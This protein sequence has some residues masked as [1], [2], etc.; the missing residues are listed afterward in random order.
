MT[1][2]YTYYAHTPKGITR[3]MVVLPTGSGKTVIFSELIKRKKLKTLVIAHR[4]EL[5]EQ[6]EQKLKMVAPD[7]EVGIF[8]GERKE[9]GKQVTIAS[10]QSAASPRHRE[11]FLKEDFELLIIDEAHHASARTY[12]ELVDY[13]G[14]K[15]FDKVRNNKASESGIVLGFTA[16]AKRGDRKALKS[17][18]DKIVYEMQLEELVEKD[19]LTRPKGLHV[20]VDIDLE[21]V[22]TVM[23][24]YKKLSLRKVMTS[25][26]AR[27]IVAKTIKKFA[28]DRSG[29]VFSCDINH[30]EM[31]HQDI[32]QAGFKSAVVHSCV[33]LDR[34]KKVLKDFSAGKLQFL[35]NPM[36]LTEGFDCPIA[37]CMIN[38]A[39]T[40]NRPLYI[41]KAGRVLRLH[42]EKEDAL[43][44]DFGYAGEESPL[45]TAQTL[46]SYVE[47]KKVDDKLELLSAEEKEAYEKKLLEELEEER[48]REEE[49]Q[50]KLKLE[51][52]VEQEYD[53]LTV[54]NHDDEDPIPVVKTGDV[55]EE[56]EQT[57]QKG[58]KQ[59]EKEELL[60]L[61]RFLKFLDV[62]TIRSPGWKKDITE[63]QERFIETLCHR[64]FDND[65]PELINEISCHQ[66]SL[67]ISSL[68]EKDGGQ[69]KATNRQI[70][71]LIGMGLEKDEAEALNFKEAS[72]ILWEVRQIKRS[73]N[74]CTA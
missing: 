52:L 45:K 22:Q 46:G 71:T 6:A 68:L 57:K 59:D 3:Q 33:P 19:F 42:P 65:P 13:L 48:K 56:E 35:I 58:E 17:V 73:E 21:E 11:Q 63:K 39:P 47:V 15:Q 31:L 66:A 67:L 50:E 1:T 2:F 9:L 12:L 41:Q 8:C 40:L 10:I 4:L 28:N 26:A 32:S 24:D 60:Y 5:L 18:F 64:C 27:E 20:T 43:L 29:I 44:I 53:P 38:A 7:V 70:K 30:A 74:L 23:G 37:D 55:E 54:E 69:L 25:P 14:F 16:T 51:V 49:A 61:L 62:P 72:S 36:I 34:R